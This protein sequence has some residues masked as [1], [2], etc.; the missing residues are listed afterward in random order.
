ML[1]ASAE[2]LGIKLQAS[3]LHL[4]NFVLQAL[5]YLL[6]L[7]ALLLRGLLRGESNAPAALGKPRD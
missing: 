1:F 5:P 3:D 4:P 2:A 7:L 6:T